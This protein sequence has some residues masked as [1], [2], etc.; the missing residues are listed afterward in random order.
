MKLPATTKDISV[1][2]LNEALHENGVLGNSNI[3]SVKHEPIGVGEGYTGDIARINLKYDND[4]LQLPCSLV[5][6]LPTSFGPARD[7]CLRLGIYQ[8]EIRFYKEIAPSSPIRTPY[9]YFGD[10]DQGND[11]YVLLLEDCSKYSQPDPELKGINYEQA[12][13]MTLAIAEFHAR[14]WDDISLPNYSFIT[15]PVERFTEENIS[16]FKQ[17]CETCF[18]SENFIQNL[19]EGGLE[20]SRALCDRY[21]H[22]REI[23]PQDK[24]TIVHSD[25]RADNV[26]FDS[27][28]KQ[29]PVIVYDW[30][31]VVFWRGVADISRLLGT[32]IDTDLR[33]KAEK[34]LIQQYH[35]RLVE[36]GVS[37]Y[38]YQECWEDYLKGYLCFTIFPLA[39]FMV[40]DQS[41]GRGK[42]RALQNIGRWFSAIVDNDAVRLMG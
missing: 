4:L 33:R 25:L 21:H 13:A 42:E 28:D 39:G 31:M 27:T 36:C 12:L 15:Q 26:Y 1:E 22:I 18:A 24:L 41:S 16:M 32:S 7:L 9:C 11:R 37:N 23:V 10:I 17:Y 3:V 6:K 34:D 2:W 14:W 30:A 19:P 8:R 35:Q 5:A 20:A 38:S 40:G 29:R